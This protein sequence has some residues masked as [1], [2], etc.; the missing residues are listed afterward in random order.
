MKPA[1]DE[2][3]GLRALMLGGTDDSQDAP[4]FAT[5]LA[6]LYAWL[7]EEPAIAERVFYMHPLQ[8]RAIEETMM[9]GHYSGPVAFMYAPRPGLKRIRARRG[10]R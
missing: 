7:N 2:P 3:P 6:K 1:A 9:V 8:M 4:D 5:E 10:R